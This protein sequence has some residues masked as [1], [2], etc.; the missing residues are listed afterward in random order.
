[1]YR[2]AIIQ[3]FF[4]SSLHYCS[5]TDMQLHFYSVH[6]LIY[7]FCAK[8][9]LIVVWNSIVI[10]EKNHLFVNDKVV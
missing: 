4:P 1:M 7:T 6:T 3:L 2:L 5:Y 8:K 9:T 10:S